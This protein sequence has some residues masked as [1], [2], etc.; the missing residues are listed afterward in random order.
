MKHSTISKIAAW[1]TLLLTVFTTVAL[2]WAIPVLKQEHPSLNQQALYAAVFVALATVTMSITFVYMCYSREQK[3]AEKGIF[4]ALVLIIAFG[5]MLC[6]SCTQPKY[7]TKGKVK[8][9]LKCGTKAGAAR[10]NAIYRAQWK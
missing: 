2:M 4:F 6:T 5:L 1:S 10:A 8:T 9:M 3:H 7:Q